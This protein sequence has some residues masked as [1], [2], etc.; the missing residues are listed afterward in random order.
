MKNAI[1]M[2]SPVGSPQWLF[3][4]FVGAFNLLVSNTLQAAF[5]DD[6]AIGNAKAL[7]LANAVTADPHTVP[8]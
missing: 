7:G 8:R 2:P 6:L 3:F 4:A 5:T 1:S